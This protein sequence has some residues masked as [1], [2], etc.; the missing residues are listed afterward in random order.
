[1]LRPC[2]ICAGTGRTPLPHLH[3]DLTCHCRRLRPPRHC[4]HDGLGVAGGAVCFARTPIKRLGAYFAPM[5]SVLRSARSN[6]YHSDDDKPVAK[7]TYDLS[8]MQARRPSSPPEQ[9]QATLAA[10]VA[11]TQHAAC[12]MQHTT[13]CRCMQHVAARN[14]QHTTCNM[15]VPAARCNDATCNTLS[16]ACSTL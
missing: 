3:R 15:P 11:R 6:Q 8:P 12:S 9:S 2:H 1:M 7:F 5:P 16:T 14:I 13:A 4:V 10:H